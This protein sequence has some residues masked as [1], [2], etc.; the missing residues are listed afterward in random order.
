MKLATLKKLVAKGEGPALEFKRSTGELREAMQSLCGFLNTSGGVVLFG[1]DRKGKIVGQQVT[2]NTIHEIT[3]ALDRFEPP[4]KITIER[5]RVEEGREIVSLSATSNHESV[6]FVYDGRAFVRVGNTT[7]KMGQARY[8]ESL[9]GR[10]HARRRWENLPAVDISLDDLDHEEILRTREDAIHNRRISA[11]TPADPGEILDRLGLRREG[12]ITQAAQVLYGRAAPAD[13][14]QCLLKLGR[15]RG[16]EISGD[17]LDNRQEHM[18]VFSMVREAMAFLD[19]TLPLSAHFTPGVIQR[20][21]RLAVPPEALR[22]AL[23]NAVMH[24]DYSDPSGHVAIAVF[25]DRVEIRSSGGFPAGITAE[26]LTGPHM[27]KPRNPLIAGAFHRTGAVEIWGWGTNRIIEECRKRD[28]D[29]PSFAEVSGYVHVTFKAPIGPGGTSSRHQVGTKL[30]LSEHQ[31]AVLAVSGE[32][33]PLVELM[34]R[35]GRSDRTKFRQQVLRPLL[36]AGLLELTIPDK[37]RS[38]KQRYRTTV[39]GRSAA[40]AADETDEDGG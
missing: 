4:A 26:M 33:Q 39:A 13:Y 36:D 14:P 16:T 31:V 40:R 9:L 29:A 32:A 7:R 18:H 38:S 23:L 2:E 28:L 20:E 35:C 24:R 1:V 19:R 6:P 37:P 3:Q 8:E 25:D 5:T 34:E 10:A 12:V 22:E 30:A 27:S 17:I 11:A 15:F 21:D